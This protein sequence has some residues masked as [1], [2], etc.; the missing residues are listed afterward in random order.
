M[1][2]APSS[3]KTQA[4]SAR[5]TNHLLSVFLC[6][7][8]VAKLKGSGAGSRFRGSL[9]RTLDL[10]QPLLLLLVCDSAPHRSPQLLLLLKL[11]SLLCLVRSRSLQL[12]LLKLPRE[13]LSLFQGSRGSL[14]PPYSP[15]QPGWAV[16]YLR[17][18]WLPDSGG[19]SEEKETACES[20]ADL[21]QS[22]AFLLAHCVQT[23]TR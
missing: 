20:D 7:C 17:Q 13:S 14:L 2:R 9:W 22:Q 6:A 5:P 10:R 15:P 1:D 21:E 12:L 4:A 8:G 3:R 23:L 16:S 19:S 18:K 11:P